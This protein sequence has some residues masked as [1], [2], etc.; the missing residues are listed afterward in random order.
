MTN[1]VP[2]AM[3]GFYSFNDRTRST[4]VGI[5]GS[6]MITF[7]VESREPGPIHSYP[8][9]QSKGRW[10]PPS[11]SQ[12]PHP[13]GLLPDDFEHGPTELPPR[14]YPQPS[15]PGGRSASP[16]RTKDND[17]GKG[18]TSRRKPNLPDDVMDYLPTLEGRLCKIE[19]GLR[20]YID[21]RKQRAIEKSLLPPPPRTHSDPGVARRPPPYPSTAPYR[22]L[23]SQPHASS[24]YVYDSDRQG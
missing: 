3:R 21:Y 6:M 10:V 8:A 13:A 2:S 11:T 20:D 12:P 5:A 18:K 1:V 9:S 22:S 19:L 17:K 24:S 23:P 7:P 4:S 16:T 15:P 14:P